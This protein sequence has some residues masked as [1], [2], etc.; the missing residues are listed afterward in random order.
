[1]R[2]EKDGSCAAL[3][4]CCTP[5]R[6]LII[7]LMM[8][9]FPGRQPTQ[10]EIDQA[11]ATTWV[12]LLPPDLK[13]VPRVPAPPQPQSTKLKIDPKFLRKIAPPTPATARISTASDRGSRRSRARDSRNCRVESDATQQQVQAP[14]QPRTEAPRPAPSIAANPAGNDHSQSGLVLPTLF[15]RRIGAAGSAGPFAQRERRALDWVQR[16]AGRWRR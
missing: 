10:A 2:D 9:W 7:V 11:R 13:N 6:F 3:P 15:R 1:M 16:Q 14:Q 12:S 5:W 4:H 8:Q